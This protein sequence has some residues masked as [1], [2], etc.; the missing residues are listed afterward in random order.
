MVWSAFLDA[1][2]CPNP[3]TTPRVLH[4]WLWLQDQVYY[5][6]LPVN[7]RDHGESESLGLSEITSPTCV[8]H[9]LIPSQITPAFPNLSPGLARSLKPIVHIS[10]VRVIGFYHSSSLTFIFIIQ[11][12]FCL[13]EMFNM[14]TLL[15]HS[16]P[17]HFFSYTIYIQ[18]SSTSNTWNTILTCHG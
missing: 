10:H 12:L 6:F 7:I 9:H 18:W 15:S 14:F 5:A 13:M 4:R 2:G 17:P 1:P 11:K 8:C 16:P 3:L